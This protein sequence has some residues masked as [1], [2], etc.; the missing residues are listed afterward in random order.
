MHAKKGFTIIELLIVGFFVA[1][2]FIIFFIQKANVD[3]MN[4]DDDRKTSINAMYYA[5][6]E[7]YLPK[8]GYFPETISEENLPVIDPQLFTD[9]FGVN[10]G[11]EG[12]S[13]TYEAANCDNSNHCKEFVLRAV[14]EKEDNYIKKGDS[15]KE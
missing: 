9:P 7:Y 2:L 14:L 11:I 5:L 15:Y 10:L 1:L 8:F 12:S 13:Y 3:A 4:R 6:T